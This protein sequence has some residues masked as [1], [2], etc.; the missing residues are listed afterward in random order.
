MSLPPKQSA[1]VKSG[2][3]VPATIRAKKPGGGT[4]AGGGINF[5]AAVTAIAGAH[6]LRG[7]A[8]GWLPASDVPVAVWAESEGAGDDLR[9]ELATGRNAEVQDKKGL[10]RGKALWTSL[11]AMVASVRDGRLDYGVLAVAP[12]SSGTVR[13]DLPKDLQRL[14]QGRSDHLT[15]IGKELHRRLEAIGGDWAAACRRMTVRVVHAL[16]ADGADIRAAKEVLRSVCA[17]DGDADAAWNALYQDAV[18]RIEHRGR[19]TVPHLLDVLGRAG[20]AI[21][22]AQFPASVSRKLADWVASTNRGFTLPT[23]RRPLPLDA[24]LEMRTLGTTIDQPEAEDAATALARYH[25]ASGSLDRDAAI[26]DAEWTGRF[27]R[28]AVVVAGPGLGKSTLMTLLADRYA[29]DG[30]PV[31][32]VKLKPVAAAMTGGAG[33]DQALRQQALAGSGVTPDQFDRAA[34]TDLVVLADGLDDCGTAHDAVARA[35]GAF[36]LGHRAARVIVTT[37]PIGYTTSALAEWQHYRLL[38]PD[39]DHGAVNL[40][41]L[42]AALEGESADADKTSKRAKRE[43]A[44][45]Q[46][47]DTISTSPLL[48]GMAAAV[49]HG[50]GGLPNTRPRLYAELVGL[51]EAGGG[52]VAPR[53]VAGAI[54]TRVLDGLGWLLMQDPLVSAERLVEQLGALLA[55]ALGRTPLA[56]AEI[57]EPTLGYWE[58]LGIVERLHHGGVAYWTFVHKSFTEFTAARHLMAMG[59]AD[60]AHELDRLVDDPDWHEVVAFAGGLGLSDEIARLFVDRRAAGHTGQMERAIALAADRDAAVSDEQVRRLA[61][62][63]FTMIEEEAPDRFDIG[64]ALA[65]L[66]E[67]RPATIAPMASARR[68]HAQPAIQLVAWACLAAAGPNAQDAA[69]MATRLTELLPT[70]SWSVRTSL[71]GG[72]RFGGRKDRDLIEWIALAA[73]DAQPV[74]NLKSF[75]ETRLAHEALGSWRFR[76]KVEALLRV[77]GVGEPVKLPWERATSKSFFDLLKPDDAWRAASKKA[78]RVLAEGAITAAGEP[79]D[80]GS[81]P[82][83]PQFGALYALSNFGEVP[84]YDIYKWD[85]PFDP[86]ALRAIVQAVAHASAID[87]QALGAEAAAVIR[88][89]E[90]DDRIDA[91]GFDLPTVD[92]PDPDWAKAATLVPD[93]A[94]LV[95]AMNHGSEWLAYLAG[96]I[97]AAARASPVQSR[98]LLDGD[99]SSLWIATA[100]VR[101]QQPVDTANAMI[102]DRLSGPLPSGAEHLF[103]GLQAGAV[104]R[105][106][107]VDAAVRAGLASSHDR[108][109]EAAAN[110]AE[111]LAQRGQPVASAVLSEGYDRWTGLES[112]T[113]N[114]VIPPSPRATLLNLLVAQDALGEERLLAAL[115]DTRSDVSSAASAQLPAAV[116]ASPSLGDAICARVAA[117]SLPPSIVAN[118]LE[119]EL[120]F[121][122][123]QV[124]AFELLLGDPDPK[125]RRA[126]VALL[127]PAYLAASRI[128]HHAARLA[129][130]DEEE[131]RSAAA[132]RMSS[133]TN[134]S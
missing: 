32:T 66:A 16:E 24:L 22:D 97:L 117:R 89:I 104:D 7:S 75:V 70:I 114:G 95:A 1:V 85:R 26:F 103:R 6:M 30:L 36:A 49:I 4:A 87:P 82:R 11:E 93:R 110:L 60:R 124:A 109:A 41:K 40:G 27:K 51:F 112:G 2:S 59:D 120:P 116:A 46:A 67:A 92:V 45:S 39:K 37:R 50:R 64:E 113:R 19:W 86:V 8:I 105:S 76:N 34:L 98:A 126:G 42:L 3:A 94:M 25:G 102:L 18:L 130:D 111:A 68:D 74:S 118:M 54:A 108:V 123:T 106:P 79:A 44:R 115:S 99:G 28:Q 121:T 134:T 122:P 10:N 43:L 72:L 5:Q 127:R 90:S 84:A 53:P 52:S 21:R 80:I 71:L 73:L 69:E 61:E 23:V 9:L 17:D 62:L 91:V 55:P 88:R 77:R 133:E 107:M 15:D 14:A 96:N 101:V 119:A 129:G 125:W 81:P 31:L 38:A 131:I 13:E 47:A 100:V 35:L 12:D 29:G 48:L 56:A 63:A 57:V 132:R 33:F 128:A 20:I 78:L 65:K 58:Q 83:L